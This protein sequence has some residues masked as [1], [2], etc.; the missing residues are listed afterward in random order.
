M[1]LLLA[2][3]PEIDLDRCPRGP[4]LLLSTTD[5]ESGALA[6][7]DPTDG[8]TADQLATTGPD[9]IV[10]DVGDRVLVANRAGGDS[11]VVYEPGVYERPVTEFVVERGGNVHDVVAVGDE[12]W[13]AL[14]ERN[15]VVRTDRNGTERGRI[16][17]GNADADGLPE[18][19]RFVVTDAGVFLA[20][21]RLDRESAW[22]PGDGRIVRLD[23]DRAE[24]DAG[25][26]TGPD[27]KLYA[28]PSDPS[29]LIVLTG[30]YGAP[31]GALLRFDPRSGTTTPIVTEAE[32]GHDLSGFAGIDG[33]AVLLGVDFDV[34]GPST[35]SCI[36]LAT[37]ALTPG[38][39]DAAWFVEAV[40]AGDRVHVA[41]RSGFLGSAASAVLTVDP[42]T[43][44]VQTLAEGFWL[45]PYA[46]R[47]VP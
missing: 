42:E 8:C 25:W 19:D 23:P 13:F 33:H 1:I 16:P 5:Y 31:D 3:L 44:D 47:W 43:C 4:H 34:A 28:D 6:T 17:L 35:V 9:A 7:V 30:R 20:L 24:V 26:D 11:V 14:Y 41:V 45:D 40:S 2:C 37:G 39:S 32:L 18:A 38:V 22:T 46:I 10:R 27:P 36:D 29:A 15:A 21:Q 12:W